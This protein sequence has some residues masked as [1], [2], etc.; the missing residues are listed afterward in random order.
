MKVAGQMYLHTE[1][2]FPIPDSGPL[3]SGSPSG[4]FD[5]V[6]VPAGGVCRFFRTNLLQSGGK[7]GKIQINPAP[8]RRPP[9]GA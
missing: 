1:F 7:N 6:S 5:I 9:A 2:L 4:G 3:R 8:P